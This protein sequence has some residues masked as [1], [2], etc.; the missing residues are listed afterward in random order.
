MKILSF[1]I[2]IVLSIN[3]F[4]QE[5]KTERITNWNTLRN[6]GFYESYSANIINAPA[7]LDWFW[8]LNIAH[9][10]NAKATNEEYHYG[11]QILFPIKYQGTAI[12]EMYIRSM[13]KAGEG[14]WAK[15][16]HSKGDH[17][18]DGKLVVKEVEV[19]INTGADFVFKPNYN[20]RSLSEVEAFIKEKKHLP[21][22]PSEKEMQQD[23]LNLNDMQ[24][25]L[26][27]K[28]EELTLYVIEQDKKFNVL[29]QENEVMKQENKEIKQEIKMLKETK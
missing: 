28:I 3:C 8:G 9:S 22:I 10:N 21:E 5:M 6:P 20:L 27:Q 25:K 24:I 18:I 11:A 13:T 15:V 23:G 16:L 29:K 12:P 1:F 17:A 26:L 4:S 7:N 14:M 2:F 19:K